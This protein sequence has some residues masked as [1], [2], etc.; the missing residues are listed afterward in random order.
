MKIFRCAFPCQI[1]NLAYAVVLL[2]PI[3]VRAAAASGTAD[4]KISVAV[5]DIRGS[6]SIDRELLTSLGSLVPQVLDSLGPFK[7]I[8]RNDIEQMLALEAMK[9]VMGCTEVS[10]LAEI[11]GA[12]GVDYLVTGNILLVSDT[13]LIQLQL[14]N[15][16]LS[17]VESRIA[18]E[19]KGSLKAL[20]DETRT[21]TKVLVRDLL[22]EH[23]G[24][25][26]I[27]VNEEGATIRVDNEIVGVSP[28]E[29]LKVAGGMHTVK[30]EKD[31]FVLYA[32]DIQVQANRN[33]PLDV[34]L[35][36]SAEFLRKYRATA[37]A[38]RT[39]AWTSIGIG[40]ASFGGSAAF[41]LLGKNKAASYDQKAKAYSSEEPKSTAT[42]NELQNLKKQTGTMDVLTLTSA[43]VGLAA[44]GVGV[45]LYVTGDPPDLYDTRVEVGSAGYR[46]HDHP[47]HVSVTLLPGLAAFGGTF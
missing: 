24:H 45:L 13:F 14:T 46:D 21:A 17:R 30:V 12:L 18:R 39:V 8:T 1:V 22:A 7:A 26:T 28:V 20:L 36:P 2:L 15:I 44:F 38:R 4:E 41:F 16:R 23:S 25:I 6:E 32:K 3:G 40:V 31:G 19:F 42:Y 5:M 10:C 43:A 27:K 34:N 11:G 9:D 29:Q 37:Q 35:R 47:V 33:T